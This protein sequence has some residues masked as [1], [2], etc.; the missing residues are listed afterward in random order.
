M[1]GVMKLR[2]GLRMALKRPQRLHNL[3]VRKGLK[4]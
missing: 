1:H 3:C 4:A 2:P